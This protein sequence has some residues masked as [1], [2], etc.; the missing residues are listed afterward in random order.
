MS[1][2]ESAKTALAAEKNRE[3]AV[4][5]GAVVP[6]SKRALPIEIDGIDGNEVEALVT[7]PT[8]SQE[9]GSV[10]QVK[11]LRPMTQK[12]R[13]KKTTGEVEMGPHVAVVLERQTGMEMMYVCNAVTASELIEK[14]PD[15]SYVGKNFAILK[16]KP[17]KG[18]QYCEVRIVQMKT[19]LW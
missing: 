17:S 4:Q 12:E 2:L 11:F 9:Q 5:Q 3:T 14:Y 15:N 6:I 1:P 8:L 13:L 18:N 19:N 16:M 7:R 10:V